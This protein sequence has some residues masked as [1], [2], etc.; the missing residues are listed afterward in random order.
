MAF[1]ECE[2]PRAIS[3][4]RLGS[5]VGFSTQVNEGFSGDEQRNR[6][7]A[8]SRG[9]WTVSII[10]PPANQR[11]GSPQS[12]IDQLKAFI[13]VVGGKADAFRLFDHLD[14]QLTAQQIGI[15]DGSNTHFQLIRTYVIGVR[16]YVR[17]ITKPITSA[18]TDYKGA[19][20][21]NTVRLYLG[22][23]LQ[24]SSA[25]SVDATTGLV[26]FVSAPGSSVVVSADAQYH[27]PVRFDLEDLPMQVEP[28]NVSSGSAIVS[29]SLPLV[30]V[31][32][33]NY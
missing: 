1:F 18:V 21:S 12:F 30:E 10:T 6:N 15:G 26:T 14:H 8:N 28:S 25:W 9:K 7:W 22:G 17:N 31:K 4:R 2:F 3:Y 23:T 13:L 27:Y 32:P 5:P 33:P 19:A 11:S 16:S 20:L 29:V 24:A